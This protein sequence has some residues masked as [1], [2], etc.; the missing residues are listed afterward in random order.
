MDYRKI[1][2]K[3]D[4]MQDEILETIRRSVQIDSV[5]GEPQKNAPYGPGPKKALDFALELGKSLGFRIGNVD[6]HAGYIEYGNGEEMVAVLGHMDVV[7]AGDG[8]KYPP[9]AGEIHD[10]IMYG[11][12]VVDDKG[13]TIGAIYGLR[14]IRDLGLPL[15]RRIRVIFGTNEECGSSCIRHYLE[16]GEE[17]PVMGITPDAEYPLIFFEKGMFTATCGC[18]NV[19]QGKIK[20]LE[21]QGGTAF[22]VVP[23]HCRL[24]LEG[25]VAV[26]ESEGVTVVRGNGTTI[27]T[28]EGVSAHGSMPEL[29]KNAA[30]LLVNAVKEIEI[31]GAYQKLFHFLETKIGRET[32]GLTLGIHYQDEE[33]GET[34]VNLGV[35]RGTAEKI[36]FILDI[37]YPKNGQQ[38]EIHQKLTKVLEEDGMELLSYDHTDMLYVPKESELVQKLMKVYRE[39]TGQTDAQP[40][41]IGGGTYAKMFKNMVAFGPVF[42]G[43][44][45]VVHQPN[46]GL[47]VEKLMQSIKLTANAMAEM[48]RK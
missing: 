38:E 13:P 47:E 24:V 5:A 2:E 27:L 8:W 45:D 10:G 6:N 4:E 14:A 3:I 9:F 42:P 28:A 41:A 39:G 37:R 7:P 1:N 22:N 29:G 36:E 23:S 40:K 15:D 31:G 20:V 32:N 17:Q 34:T 30:I 12:G 11:R 46:E 33:T 35:I 26:P 25:D 21:F 44:P 48:A 16:K 43:D 19:Q 18:D